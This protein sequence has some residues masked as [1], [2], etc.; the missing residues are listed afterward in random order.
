MNR[1]PSK[2]T[3]ASTNAF[4]LFV[5][6]LAFCFFFDSCALTASRCSDSAYTT[7]WTSVML[8]SLTAYIW[9]CGFHTG[10][11]LCSPFCVVVRRQEDEDVSVYNARCGSLI[12]GPGRDGNP[13]RALLLISSCSTLD[14]RVR[15]ALPW[16]ACKMCKR[17][18]G[19]SHTS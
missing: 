5:L 9:C 1:A 13:V 3:L 12:R 17:Q 14:A 19:R 16:Q 11:T 8:F 7:P 10:W 4:S 15:S 2:Y 18:H 6:C